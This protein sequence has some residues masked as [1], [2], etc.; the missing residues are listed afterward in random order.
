MSYALTIISAAAFCVSLG[1]VG[2]VTNGEPLQLMIPAMLCQ[3]VVGIC[4]ALKR[5]LERRKH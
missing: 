1:F 5:S 3:A 2:A 4:V